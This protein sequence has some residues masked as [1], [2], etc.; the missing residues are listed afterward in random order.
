MKPI[1]YV[2]VP[3]NIP[4]KKQKSKTKPDYLLIFG[5]SLVLINSSL[6]DNVIILYWYI[7]FLVFTII[8]FSKGIRVRDT[9]IKN[10]I[11]STKKNDK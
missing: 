2:V 4:N 6:T 9:L 3:E 11:K 5:L 8:I 7:L 1:E 10:I